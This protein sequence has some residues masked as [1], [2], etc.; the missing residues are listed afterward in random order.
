MNHDQIVG[1]WKQLQGRITVQ[2]A[3]L[4][5]DGQTMVIGQRGLLLGR[6]Q[7]LRGSAREQS[8]RQLH[9]WRGRNQNLHCGVRNAAQSAGE[10][11]LSRLRNQPRFEQK[12]LCTL[13]R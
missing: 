1:N 7:A 11:T 2:W 5:H 3:K 6:I 12:P 8:N 13:V 4:T 10:L 9:E